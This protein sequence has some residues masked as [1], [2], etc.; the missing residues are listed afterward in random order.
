[1]GPFKQLRDDSGLK[2]RGQVVFGEPGK[3][4]GM[5]FIGEDGEEGAKSR[6]KIRRVDGAKGVALGVEEQEGG[7]RGEGARKR[8]GRG[9]RRRE[10]TVEQTEPKMGGEAGSKKQGAVRKVRRGRGGRQVE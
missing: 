7:K 1:M 6:G 4:L 8:V 9:R 2:K 3:V 5:G 10:R